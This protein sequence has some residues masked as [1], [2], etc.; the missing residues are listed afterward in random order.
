[1]TISFDDVT[2]MQIIESVKAICSSMTPSPLNIFCSISG[3][4]IG[5]LDDHAIWQV[6]QAYPRN[7]SYDNLEVIVEDLR[8]SCMLS[9]RPSPAWAQQSPKRLKELV[10]RDPVGSCV[11]FLT[12]AYHQNNRPAMSRD[13]NLSDGV[14][15]RKWESKYAQ[16]EFNWERVQLADYLYR[17]DIKTTEQLALLLCE[18]DALAGLHRTPTVSKFLD[19]V[20]NEESFNSLIVH[21]SGWR[22]RLIER[23]AKQHLDSAKANKLASGAF[24]Y[25]RPENQEPSA[26][27]LKLAEKAKQTAE[28]NDIWNSINNIETKEQAADM[29]HTL[30]SGKLPDMSQAKTP[31][32][33]RVS[34]K[35]IKTSG[36][37]NLGIIGK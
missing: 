16:A 27:Q 9:M 8:Q 7:R 6:I 5:T 1:M 28:F 14:N 15:W 34:P 12:R 17:R 30:E 21:Y 31:P 11:Y 37:L 22:D 33:I 18:V 35:L 20:L 19:S 13:P 36:K 4:R 3:V 32:K 29:R 25:I 23:R 10:K 2:D 26:R 24:N